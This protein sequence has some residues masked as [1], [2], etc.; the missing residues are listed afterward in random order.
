MHGEFRENIAYGQ[1]D[2]GHVVLQDGLEESGSHRYAMIVPNYT[3]IGIG[4]VRDGNT[5]YIV[6]ILG[7]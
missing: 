7:E 2:I 6:H 1:G 5:T 3:K 4:Y